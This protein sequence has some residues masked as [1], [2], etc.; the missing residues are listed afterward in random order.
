MNGLRQ[1]KKVND[2]ERG[3]NYVMMRCQEL[4]GS[5]SMEELMEL[6]KVFAEATGENAELARGMSAFYR[7]MAQGSSKL[8]LGE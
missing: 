7:D 4:A 8:K 6:A 1:E 5:T 2:F 3:Y